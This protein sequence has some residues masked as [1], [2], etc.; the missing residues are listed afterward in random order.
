LTPV[1]DDPI[2]I[3]GHWRT[4]STL[5]HQLLN[6]DPNLAAPTLLQVAEPNCF[7]CSY[8]YYLP[9]FSALLSKTR[10]MDNV[11]IGI[12]EPQED[13]YAIFRLSDFSPIER[14]VFPTDPKYFVNDYP[15][16]LP[17]NEKGIKE[18]EAKLCFFF[19]KLSFFHGKT[20]ISKNPFNS[21]RIRELASLFPKAR[22]IHIV[23]HP[24]AVIP[25]TIHLWKVVME[26]N[27][28]NLKGSNPGIEQVTEGLSRLLNTIERDKSFLAGENF[29]EIRFEDL[30]ADPDSEVRKIYSRFQMP[31]ND[32]L[33]D[34]IRSY[35][36]N[37]R[38]YRK[39][40]FHLSEEEKERIR[41]QLF[42]HMHIFNYQ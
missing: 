4:G 19:R 10:P 9:V 32:A 25:S 28:L 26:Q 5:L 11:K 22:F 34:N 15:S 7:I 42:R 12:N 31:F 23:R 8:R 16:F 24:Y 1:P 20:I 39:N 13:E 33:C 27:R 37:L 2:F 21:L 30:E 3:I 29:Y 14:L 40:E 41:R 35:M 38:N 6:L 18:W 36:D 17:E